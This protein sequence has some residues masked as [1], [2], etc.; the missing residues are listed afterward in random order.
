MKQEVSEE[1]WDNSEFSKQGAT[2]TPKM[3]KEKEEGF[4]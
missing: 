4:S 3:W 1:T 2:N